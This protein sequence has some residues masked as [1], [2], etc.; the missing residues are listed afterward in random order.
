VAIVNVYWLDD[1]I[2]KLECCVTIGAGNCIFVVHVYKNGLWL[3]NILI[4]FMYNGVIEEFHN[5]S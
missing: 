4:I 5:E 2:H 1:A 3:Q